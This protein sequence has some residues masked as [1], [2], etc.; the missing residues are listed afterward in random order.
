MLIFM[1]YCCFNEMEI[2][3]TYNSIQGYYCMIKAC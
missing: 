2:G 1:L 3:F